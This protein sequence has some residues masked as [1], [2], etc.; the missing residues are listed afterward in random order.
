LPAKLTAEARRSRLSPARR[1]QRMQI[2]LF[3]ELL[4]SIPLRL[5]NLSQLEM[6]RQLLRPGGPA[7]LMQLVFNSDEVKNDQSMIF[8]VPTATQSLIDEYWKH[9]RPML[10]PGTRQSLV[11][12][13]GRGN[14]ESRFASPWSNDGGEAA[15][16]HSHDAAPVPTPR[17][18]IYA[19]SKSRRVSACAAP[20]GT[21]EL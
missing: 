4:L 19:G 12:H 1:V 8:D 2:A 6:G 10:E 20:A 21:Q 15:C 16:R 14:E 18:K 7:K 11:D 5:Q 17:R 9:F 3:L 13:L